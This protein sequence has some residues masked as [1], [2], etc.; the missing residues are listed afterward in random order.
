MSDS[1]CVFT[2]VHLCSIIIFIF[3]LFIIIN[4][5]FHYLLNMHGQVASH[6]FIKE[7]LVVDALDNELA[8]AYILES[9]S[10]VGEVE[11]LGFAD[12]KHVD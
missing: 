9:F 1:T 2:E 11:D 7:S 3:F 8:L 6:Q 10:R 12:L 5:V 4:L